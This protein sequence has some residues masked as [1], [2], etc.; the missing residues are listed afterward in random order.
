MR[1][2]MGEQAMLSWDSGEPVYQRLTN[3]AEVPLAREQTTAPAP[4]PCV[5]WLVW[6]HDGPELTETEA[7]GWTRTTVLVRV[8]DRRWRLGGVWVPAS[9]VRRLAP[10]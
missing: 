9:D 6:E 3:E 5:V 8:Y 4:V 10:R 1:S 2:I 7:I